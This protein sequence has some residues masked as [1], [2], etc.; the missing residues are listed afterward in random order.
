MFE[1][2]IDM[3]RGTLESFES[4]NNKNAIAVF[5]KDEY[6]DKVNSE[7]N[8]VIAEIIKRNPEKINDTLQLLSFIRKLER[9]GDQVQNIAEEIVFY[10]EAKVIKHQKIKKV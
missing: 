3:L 4:E 2:A 6:L 8:V 10:I 9:V 5:K 7:A 1:I